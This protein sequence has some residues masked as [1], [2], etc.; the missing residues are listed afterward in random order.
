MP[1]T[2]SSD[3]PSSSGWALDILIK[4]TYRLFQDKFRFHMILRRSQTSSF[5][6]WW[7][8]QF[9]Q[10]LHFQLAEEYLKNP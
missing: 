4:T 3:V 9:A 1:D 7:D 6:Y 5:S 8:L 10:V 2:P